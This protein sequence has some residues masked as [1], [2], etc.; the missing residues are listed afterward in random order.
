MKKE[1]KVKTPT[2]KQQIAS[3]RAEIREIVRVMANKASYERIAEMNKK[4]TTSLRD[5][6]KLEVKANITVA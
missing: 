4:L 6:A 3:K 2:L 1:T 5:L